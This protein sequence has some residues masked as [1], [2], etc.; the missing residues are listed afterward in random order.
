MVK[1]VSQTLMAAFGPLPRASLPLYSLSGWI[2]G[3]LDAAHEGRLIESL[4]GVG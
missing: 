1:K 3:V 4:V 2:L